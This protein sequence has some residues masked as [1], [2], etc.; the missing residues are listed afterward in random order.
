M[1]TV[2]IV[3]D[4]ALRP[5]EVSSAIVRGVVVA[6]HGVASGAKGDPRF[7]GGTLAMQAPH[8]AAAGLDIARF[9]GGTINVDVA[10]HRIVLD[11]PVTTLRNVRWHPTEPAEDFSFVDCRIGVTP[12]RLVSGLVY[13]PDPETKP[14]H[15][16]PPTIVEIVAPWIEGAA[17]GAELWLE[18]SPTQA[19]FETL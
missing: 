10:P 6:G 3:T 8:F 16:Q 4:D 11:G 9:H 15:H 14:E 12:Q 13:R 2:G 7:P 5:R 18:V 1:T 19:H 17:V